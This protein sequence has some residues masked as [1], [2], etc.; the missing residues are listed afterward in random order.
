M[1]SILRVTMK[2]NSPRRLQRSSAQV[3]ALACGLSFWI[4]GAAAVAQDSATDEPT[5]L[6]LEQQSL[7]SRFERLESVAA[8]LA[9]L[10]ANSEPERAEQ[11][12]RA[13]QASREKG[14]AEQFD[15][16]VALLNQQR[17]SAAASNQVE[18]QTELE[19]LLQVLLEDPGNAKRDA[20]KRFL[21]D[22]IRELGK[23]IR[24]Q[25]SLQAQS[26]AAPPESNPSPNGEDA[27]EDAREDAGESANQNPSDKQAEQA[28]DKQGELQKQAGDVQQK[29]EQG[30]DT[31]ES[32]S[33]GSTPQD[34]PPG[35]E[36]ESGQPSQSPQQGQPGESGQQ[37]QPGDAGQ[38]AEPSSDPIERA[39]Q[40]VEQARRAMQ[41]AEEK[42]RG[43]NRKGASEEQLK[44]QRELE[45]ARA[46]LERILRQLREEEMEQLLAKLAARFRN[47]LST[48][49]AIYDDTVSIA[50]RK[51]GGADRQLMLES[52]RLSRREAELVR[53]A[54]KALNLLRE[55]GTSVAFP[56]VVEQIT[57]DMRSVTTRLAAADSGPITQTIELDII[58][59]LEDMIAA[60]DKA[61]DELANQQQSPPQQGQGGGSPGESPLVSK[62]A[63]LRMIRTLQARVYRRTQQLGDLAANPEVQRADIA[64][65]LDKLA[66]RQ[67]SI[68]QA[69]RD[70]D[71]QVNQ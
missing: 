4:A 69:T 21:K 37:G 6:S 65:E 42:L 13:I 46:E 56:E 33:E 9:E 54:E 35:G 19:F 58:A 60:L 70:L 2:P 40:R 18:L 31:A 38:P 51:A 30:G 24:Q 57:D 44:A 55:D 8:R 25:R 32:G 68:F 59:G 39:A 12:R 63:E 17:L 16:I 23:L 45:A 49:K 34:S 62:I 15:D 7:A 3:F 64:A 28:A 36:N 11:L 27:R 48:Q 29:L 66:L 43:A 47:M 53:D 41:Q 5:G 10:A 22:R 14:L 61:R 20:M 26:E 1:S 67:Q 52:I 50:D 71:T